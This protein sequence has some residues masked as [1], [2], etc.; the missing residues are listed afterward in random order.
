MSSPLPMT[1]STHHLPAS[2]MTT[3]SGSGRHSSRSASQAVLRSLLYWIS[4]LT[5]HHRL[6]VPT[7]LNQLDTL[8]IS[9]ADCQ[10]GPLLTILWD[11]FCRSR[12]GWFDS[13]HPVEE[14]YKTNQT[15]QNSAKS[16]LSSSLFSTTRRASGRVTKWKQDRVLE[17]DT[18]DLSGTEG[19]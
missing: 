12:S 19:L 4:V 10:S 11:P 3:T 9:S 18:N 1:V 2:L 16:V 13:R 6:S 17:K 7:N 8:V 14:K 15:F 5:S